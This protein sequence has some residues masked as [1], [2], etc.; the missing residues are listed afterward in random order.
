MCKKEAEESWRSG[1][2]SRSFFC[3]TRLIR[4]VFNSQVDALAFV[5]WSLCLVPYIASFNNI[6]ASE[7]SHAEKVSVVG[8]QHT[9]PLARSLR[10]SVMRLRS[11]QVVKASS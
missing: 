3:K 10:A 7:L 2:I 11:H 1:R 6:R 4:D 8:E 9:P 5:R